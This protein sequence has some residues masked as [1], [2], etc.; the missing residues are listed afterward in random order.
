[1]PAKLP[2]KLPAVILPVL[3]LSSVKVAPS[4]SPLLARLRSS[5]V[6]PLSVGTPSFAGSENDRIGFVL[7]VSRSNEATSTTMRSFWLVPSI[8]KLLL[9]AEMSPKVWSWAPF[10]P[11]EL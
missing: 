7:P 3:R 11:L 4:V 5:I 9:L 10:P 8:V 2:S 6:S 1:M